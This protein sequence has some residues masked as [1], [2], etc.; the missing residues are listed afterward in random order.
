[1]KKIWM[2]ISIFL[3]GLVSG[4]IFAAKW[5]SGDKVQVT[6][7]R[8]RIKGNEN[9]M[10]GITDVKQSRDKKTRQEKK[11]SREARHSRRKRGSGFI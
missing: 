3:T 4:V 9:T 10:N 1:M 8:Q 6:V 5:I 2:Y 11:A 7:K